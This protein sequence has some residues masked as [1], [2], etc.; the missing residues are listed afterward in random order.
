M[1][2]GN[3]IVPVRFEMLA[4]ERVDCGRLVGLGAVEIDIAG[5]SLKL[6]G[7]QIVRYAP[8]ILEYNP[9]AF[10]HA[11]PENGSLP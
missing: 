8:Y 9:P 4:I 2:Q 3:E 10:R 7:V 1:R 5:I 6:T 11:G